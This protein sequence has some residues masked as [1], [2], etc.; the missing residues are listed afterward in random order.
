MLPWNRREKST[1]QNRKLHE[2]KGKTDSEP[3]PNGDWNAHV[4]RKFGVLGWV[5]GLRPVDCDRGF[6][7][8]SDG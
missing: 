4:V 8:G 1:N 6:G 2:K 5:R 3:K 7:L